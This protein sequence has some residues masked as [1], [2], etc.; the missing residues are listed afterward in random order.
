M[1]DER[2]EEQASLYVLGALDAA[3]TRVFESALRQDPE[4]Q[5]LVTAL[6]AASDAVAGDALLVAPPA[7]LKQKILDEVEQRK[8]IVPLPTAA[9]TSPRISWFPWA[10]AACLAIFCGMLILRQNH[11]DEEYNIQLTHLNRTIAALQAA[12]NDLHAVVAELQRKNE[13]AN[14]RIAVL[15]S[16]V[17][18]SKAVAVTLWDNGRQSGMLVVQ[19]LGALPPDKDYQLWVIDP[20]AESPIDAGVF[21]VDA[22]G[23]LRAGFTAKTAVKAAGKFAVT[24][25][26]KGGAPKPQGKM[27]LLG[28]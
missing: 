11:R 4:L 26:R 20:N 9:E 21:K 24:V 7:G 12:T 16:L 3:E 15:D 23:N 27:V 6:R 25:E 10:L 22:D 8:K 2:M 18:D 19:K 14:L 5:R 28:S 1:I 17:P 13:L